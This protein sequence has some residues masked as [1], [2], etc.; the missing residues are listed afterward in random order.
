MQNFSHPV[1]PGYGT[2]GTCNRAFQAGRRGEK[3]SSAATNIEETKRE[4][5]KQQQ[6]TARLGPGADSS[7]AA[8]A[9]ATFP[10]AAQYGPDGSPFN[11]PTG[12][13]TVNRRD[14]WPQQQPALALDTRK[15]KLASRNTNSPTAIH[16]VCNDST[17]RAAPS[18]RKSYESGK[19][20]CKSLKHKSV[21]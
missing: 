14:N 5:A 17:R 4:I 11:G 2:T 13:S 16:I 15:K 8:A 12:R 21:E 7:L 9:Q 3:S 18:R 20:E 6:E 10:N 1:S 19:A